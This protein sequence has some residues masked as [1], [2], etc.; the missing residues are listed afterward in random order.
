MA[1]GNDNSVYATVLSGFD[2]ALESYGVD[3]TDLFKR[4][5]FSSDYFE[6]PVNRLFQHQVIE[7]LR[8]AEEVTGDPHFVINLADKQKPKINGYLGMLLRTAPDLRHAIE[9][10]KRYMHVYTRGLGWKFH[11]QEGFVYMELSQNTSDSNPKDNRLL[12][13]LS[14]AQGWTTMRDQCSTPVRLSLVQLTHSCNGRKRKYEDFFRCAVDFDS[15]RNRLVFPVSQLDLPMSKSDPEL[16][17]A[18]WDLVNLRGLAKEESDLLE[19][20]RS[21]IKFLLPSGRCTVEQ[22]AQHLPMNRRTLQRRL[23]ELHGVSFS[24]L[25]IE[26]RLFL[27]K[28]YLLDSNKSI[29]HIAYALGYDEP[30]NMSRFFKEH[31]GVSPKEWRELVS[32]DRPPV[33]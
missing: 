26:E 1:D 29:A 8:E 9:I 19:Q 21:S 20:V 25:L 7:L 28:T 4:L 17:L 5:G 13:E 3:Y 22:V 23:K 18:I 12:T 6:V 33:E 30:S 16:H 2:S 32:P 27:A 11:Q 14:L 31:E 10:S 24:D 15:D